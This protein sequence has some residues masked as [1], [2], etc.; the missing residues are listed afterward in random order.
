MQSRLV[1]VIGQE[2]KRLLSLPIEKNANLLACLGLC[3]AADRMLHVDAVISPGLLHNDYVI[4]DRYVMSSL[5]YQGMH[6]PTDF[7]NEINR[8]APKP[9]LTIVLDIPASLAYER[10]LLR[11]GAK[12]FYE[13]KESL[14]KIR[15]RYLHFAKDDAANTVLIN[16][17]SSIDHVTSHIHHVIRERFFTEDPGEKC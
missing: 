12:D 10:L 13:N 7:V 16:S 6:L 9:C 17:S 4:L 1:R 15:A 14:E 8:F 11:P 2:T 5:V 3:F